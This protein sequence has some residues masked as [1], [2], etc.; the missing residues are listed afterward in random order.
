MNLHVLGVG[1]D[2]L[3]FV[4][5]GSTYIIPL[6]VVLCLCCDIGLAL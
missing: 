3:D 5:P 4:C 1:V 2:A 6:I